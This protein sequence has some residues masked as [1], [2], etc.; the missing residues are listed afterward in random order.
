MNPI[1][2]VLGAF[3]ALIAVALLAAGIGVATLA[4][5]GDQAGFHFSPEYTLR[6]DAVALA[7]SR[8]DLAPSPADWLPVGFA[9]VRLV[10]RSLDGEP[11][12]VGIGPADRV[13]RYLAG[14]A[15]DEVIGLGDRATDVTLRAVTGG[16]ASP[17]ASETFWDLGATTSDSQ[18]V[19]WDARSGAWSLVIMNAGGSPGVAVAASFGVRAP[20]LLWIGIGIAAA[21]ILLGVLA[22]FIL[23]RPRRA[24]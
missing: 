1:R 21:G 8:I 7:S 18:T 4:T 24:V 19:T 9:S 15:H 20:G 11:V 17:P 13:E 5:G 16:A 10:V 22:A 3:A 23:R 2:L 14:V 12:F 6:T